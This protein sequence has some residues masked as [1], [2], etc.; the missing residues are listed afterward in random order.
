M[1]HP[2]LK[3]TTVS[4]LFLFVLCV[5]GCPGDGT[6][7]PKAKIGVTATSHTF[8][9]DEDEWTFQVW[10]SG[11]A[12]TTLT[13]SVSDNRDWI[14]TGVTGTTSASAAEPQT[15]TVTIDRDAFE[16]ATYTGT[17]TVAATG[18]TSVSVKITASSTPIVP[19]DTWQEVV[20]GDEDEYAASYELLD[21]G[22][23]VF[24]GYTTSYGAG[25]ADMY[26]VKRNDDG[27]SAWQRTFGGSKAEE[28]V[29]FD[30]V[31]D[32]G[33]VLTGYTYSYGSGGSDVY[34]VRTDTSGNKT[35]AKAFGGDDNDVGMAVAST[36][37]GGFIVTGHT[38]SYGSGNAE[39]FILKI[40]SLGNLEWADAFGGTA[41]DYGEWVKETPDGGFMIG[42]YTYS[43]G[44]GTTDVFI[45]KTD[46]SGD[47]I[48]KNGTGADFQF[49]RVEGVG[50]TSVPEVENTP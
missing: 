44:D 45:V 19:V 23:V 28:G 11:D 7:T 8:D 31:G 40:N 12:G 21:D 33:F 30:T 1:S 5:T 2:L 36:T 20:G 37:D 32:G 18:L 26:F 6:S 46:D 9:L 35:W 50:T 15:V 24:C 34:L 3:L 25:Q 13:F 47:L 42:G 39:V 17:V 49:R 10:N 14:A 48:L 38:F 4:A 43:F 27:S 29:A 41:A 22:S 16:K